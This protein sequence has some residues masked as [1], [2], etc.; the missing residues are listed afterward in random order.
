MIL[1]KNGMKI[2]PPMSMQTRM[3]KVMKAMKMET[4]SMMIMWVKAR[5]TSHED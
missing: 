1:Y 4:V 3:T 2:A 5:A